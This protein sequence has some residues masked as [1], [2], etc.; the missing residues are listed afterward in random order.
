[1]LVHILVR[2]ISCLVCIV[3]CRCFVLYLF[4][5]A[6]LIS[7]DFYDST[8]ENDQNGVPGTFL[9]FSIGKNEFLDVRNV[10]WLKF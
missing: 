10:F 6:C 9:V 7:R 8:R 4:L 2:L 5:C 3:R 1:M